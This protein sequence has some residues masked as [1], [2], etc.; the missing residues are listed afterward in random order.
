MIERNDIPL[1][2]RN[3][4][5]EVHF[6][7]VEIINVLLKQLDEGAD[8]ETLSSS[9]DAVLLHMQEHFSGE[10]NLMQEIR[11]PTYRLHKSDHDKILNEARYIYMDWRTR[12]DRER[13][14]EYFEEDI[15]QWLS[16]HI[17]A[18]DTPMADF[19]VEYE[20]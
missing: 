2:S 18:M 9:F 8:F 12:K 11:Y 6:E 13:L 1:V 5:N 20:R 10:E 4:M 16:Q 19:L 17:K 7:E 3:D 14:R 15:A